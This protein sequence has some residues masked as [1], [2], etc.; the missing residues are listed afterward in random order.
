MAPPSRHL[1]FLLRKLNDLKARGAQRTGADRHALYIG[2]QGIAGRFS[3]GFSVL[4]TLPDLAQLTCRGSFPAPVLSPSPSLRGVPPKPPGRS[5]RSF[6]APCAL[7]LPGRALFP[8]EELQRYLM[9]T[10][11]LSPLSHLTNTFR[12]LWLMLWTQKRVKE[13]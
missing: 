7:Q 3:L 5:Q 1:L 12:T 9:I 4:G 13:S 8:T 6:L 10:S 11:P 2:N